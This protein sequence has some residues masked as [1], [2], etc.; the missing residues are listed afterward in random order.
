MTLS[1][2]L[3]HDFLIYFL[4]FDRT[5]HPRVTQLLVAVRQYL[6][7]HARVCLLNS[8]HSD[9]Q[10]Q[11]LTLLAEKSFDSCSYIAKA[12]L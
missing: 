12:I 1:S 7:L 8:L 5:H 2:K 3:Q 10:S 9:W 6:H 4:M 11:M